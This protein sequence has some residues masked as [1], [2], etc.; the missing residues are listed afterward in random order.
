MYEVIM[1]YLNFNF[2]LL[3]IFLELAER[4]EIIE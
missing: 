3:A 4:A 1:W 2:L